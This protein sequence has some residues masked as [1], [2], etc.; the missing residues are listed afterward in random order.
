MKR[1]DLTKNTIEELS[2]ELEDL[3]NKIKELRFKASSGS[4]KNVKEF[5]ESKKQVARILTIINNKA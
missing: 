2:K 1:K 4:L 5:K 3:R